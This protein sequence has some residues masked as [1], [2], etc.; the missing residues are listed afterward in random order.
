MRRHLV[1]ASLM[2]L[3]GWTASAQQMPCPFEYPDTPVNRSR[4]VVGCT[5][6]CDQKLTC[7][8]QQPAEQQSIPQATPQAGK[9]SSES[10]TC[11]EGKYWNSRRKTCVSCAAGASWDARR[12]SC[13]CGV[14]RFVDP[15]T[16]RCVSCPKN[17]DWEKGVCVCTRSLKSVLAGNSCSPKSPACMTGSSW[18]SVTKYCVAPKLPKPIASLEMEFAE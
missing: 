6:Q 17:W 9:P 15:K 7:A 3:F 4:G 10:G 11:R 12:S 1:L 16:Q 13:D 14:G 2:M 18:D 5:L 8:G